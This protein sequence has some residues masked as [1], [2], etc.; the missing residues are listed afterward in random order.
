MWKKMK[1]NPAFA[2][3]VDQSKTSSKNS[4][5]SVANNQEIMETDIEKVDGLYCIEHN[6]LDTQPDLLEF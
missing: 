4:I 3:S 2:S 6:S 1:F 5:N